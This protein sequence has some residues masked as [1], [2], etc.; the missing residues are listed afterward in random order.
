MELRGRTI[1]RGDVESE[2][3]VLETPFNFTTDFDPRTGNDL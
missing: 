2:A 1:N 3:V